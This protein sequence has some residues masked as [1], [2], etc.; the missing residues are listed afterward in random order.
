MHAQVVHID[1]ANDPVLPSDYKKDEDPKIYK[2]EKTGRGPLS[3]EWQV[4]GIFTMRANH[5]SW[6]ERGGVGASFNE[7]KHSHGPCKYF[8]GPYK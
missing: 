2:S 3:G 5:V 1:I 8:H 4:R 7:A 6:C